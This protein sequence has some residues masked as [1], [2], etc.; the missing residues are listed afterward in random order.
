M[1][2]EQTE[3]RQG[4][5]GPEQ[6]W[7]ARR[8]REVVMRLLRGEPLEAISREVAVEIYRLEQWRRRA[9]E[10]MGAALKD[11]TGDPLEAELDAA[12]RQIGTLS[13]DM[14]L[15]RRQMEQHRPF[16]VRR[17]RK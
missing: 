10:G 4:A 13:M 1:K 9:L 14:E 11:R 15:M 3:Q 6:R 17:S 2:K 12:K 16:V 5:L 8:K 7:S